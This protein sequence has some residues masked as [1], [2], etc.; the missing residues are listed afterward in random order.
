[1]TIIWG[2]FSLIALY[3]CSRFVYAVPLSVA[4]RTANFGATLVIM[5]VFTFWFLFGCLSE[6][7]PDLYS[8]LFCF[9]IGQVIMS[10][11]S[12]SPHLTTATRKPA[13]AALSAA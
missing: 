6:L 3:K 10:Y 5:N 13:T 4:T 2:F 12:K 8:F 7:M 9:A 11:Y 1:V